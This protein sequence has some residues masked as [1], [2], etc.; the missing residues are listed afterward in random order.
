[1]HL[2][3][4]ATNPPG[5]TTAPAGATT[6]PSLRRASVRASNRVIICSCAPTYVNPANAEAIEKLKQIQDEAFAQNCL[7][8]GCPAIACEQ[9]V[10]GTCEPDPSGNSGTCQNLYAKR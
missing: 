8:V 3:A 10:L 2:R 9:P 5:A 7:P 4:A 6:A 1:M